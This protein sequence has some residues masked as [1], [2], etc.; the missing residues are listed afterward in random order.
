[1]GVPSDVLSIANPSVDVPVTN[2][3]SVLVVTASGGPN[4]LLAGPPAGFTRR[5]VVGK[6]SEGGFVVTNPIGGS[7]VQF[8]VLVNAF[9]YAARTS[10]LAADTDL[11]FGQSVY[12]APGDTLNGTYTSGTSALHWGISY[13]DFP[14]SQLVAFDVPLINGDTI[15]VPTPPT[16]KSHIL[17]SV[18]ENG[19]EIRVYNPGSNTPAYFS[20]VNG[21]QLTGSGTIAPGA[22]GNVIVNQGL[23][24]DDVTVS[25]AINADATGAR[26]HGAYWVIDKG[27][28]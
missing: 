10:D 23:A 9:V 6:V 26:A 22:A 3:R 24:I 11:G 16:G 13:V 7:N 14:L 20:K 15:V 4:L 19:P 1:M 25:L 28:N 5:C 8:D 2:A 27:S 12:L 18:G 21:V 17:D